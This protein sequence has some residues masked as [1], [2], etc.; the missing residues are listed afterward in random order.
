MPLQIRNYIVT[1]HTIDVIRT[2]LLLV[3]ASA[4]V[5][6]SATTRLLGVSFSMFDR[7]VHPVCLTPTWDQIC[8]IVRLLT[9]LE[10]VNSKT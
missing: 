8:T 4:V 1:M 6:W 5:S 3:T 7:E 2:G 9:S 10:V